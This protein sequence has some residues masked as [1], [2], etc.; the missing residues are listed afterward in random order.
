MSPAEGRERGP[1]RPVRSA[2]E[3]QGWAFLFCRARPAVTNGSNPKRRLQMKTPTGLMRILL[4]LIV[5]GTLALGA[6]PALAAH[7]DGV[8]QLD[9][10]AKASTC[11]TAFPNANPPPPFL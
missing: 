3:R 11:G 2:I 4:G 5:L 6:T 1:E 10:D 8:F 9:G 7:N